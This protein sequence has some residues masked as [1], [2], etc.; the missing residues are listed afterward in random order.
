MFAYEIAYL[1]IPLRHYKAA[2]D[3]IGAYARSSESEA[4]LLGCFGADIGALNRIAVL[5]RF[6]SEAALLRER[7][8][9]MA[10][11]S[12]FGC[13]AFLTSLSL[14]A[15][16]PFMDLP[17]VA[18]GPHGPF[19]E[20]RT[21]DLRIGGLPILQEAWRQKLPARAEISPILFALYALDG[22]PRFTHIWPYRSLDGRHAARA[23]A[24]ARGLW[25]PN[26]FPGTTPLPMTSEI[27]TALP[28]SPLT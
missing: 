11:T 4:E 13:G 23:E 7:A 12:P 1:G 10:S 9:L 2:S 16:A 22:T 8:R 26:A 18:P 25:P 24:V 21:Y 17:P 3:A 5:R 14:Q 20:I 6:A 27:Y 19:Y 28:C 15:F